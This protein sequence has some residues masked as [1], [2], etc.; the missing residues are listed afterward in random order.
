MAGEEESEE[1]RRCVGKKGGEQGNRSGGTWSCSG[2]SGG[3]DGWSPSSIFLE[4][5]LERESL[6]SFFK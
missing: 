3:G 2:G 5:P 6:I 1:N 4:Q